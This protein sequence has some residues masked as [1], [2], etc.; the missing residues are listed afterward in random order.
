MEINKQTYKHWTIKLIIISF[1]LC[2]AQQNTSF[3]QSTSWTEVYGPIFEDSIETNQHDPA[4]AMNSS[5]NALLSWWQKD[6]DN[7]YKV[8]VSFFNS[9]TETWSTPTIISDTSYNRQTRAPEVAFNDDG[10]A[11]IIWIQHDGTSERTFVNIFDGSNW[12]GAITLDDEI[13]TYNAEGV[14]IA[15]NNQGTI[16]AVWDQND[17]SSNRLY[18]RVYIA[19]V[20]SEKTILDDGSNSASGAQVA[21][22]IY[23]RAI[24][25]WQQK[26]SDDNY[27]IY[28]KTYNSLQSTWSANQSVISATRYFPGNRV[29]TNKVGQAMITWSQRDDSTSSYRI[30]TKQYNFSTGNLGSTTTLDDGTNTSIVQVPKIAYNNY[31]AVVAWSQMVDSKQR[32]YA[33]YYQE[34][35]SG[36]EAPQFVDNEETESDSLYDVAISENSLAMVLTNSNTIETMHIATY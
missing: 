9:N 14:G 7:N 27:H 2:L 26:D 22:D 1:I 19:G 36:W 33:A 18:A 15:M 21:F 28:L 31:D 17:S 20:W 8:Y 29:A 16:I 25:T 35:V 5:N 34:N 30:Y 24:V 6:A 4:L 13:N 11:A 12:L 23:G 10:E 3:A 32:T